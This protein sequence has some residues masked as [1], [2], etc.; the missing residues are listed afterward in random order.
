MK[1]QAVTALVVFAKAPVEGLAKT[2]LIPALGPK[3]AAALADRLLKRAVG[4]AASSGFAYIEL[5]VTPSLEHPSFQQLAA[6][7]PL[8]ITLQGE[9]DLGQRMSRCMHRLLS[10]YERVLLM[11]TDAP[12]LDSA[13]LTQA[14]EALA[15]HDAVFVPA[16]DGGYVL[17][18]LSSPQPALFDGIPWGS[19][20]VMSLTR[21]R[22][23]QSGLRLVEL[24]PMSDID[25]AK[26]L[27][28]LPQGWLP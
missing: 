21:D 27:I 23:Q 19:D 14:S 12:G 2:R 5:C 25:E 20:Q 4:T 8:S 15:H 26:D 3:G 17:I 1:G 18:G 28:Y 6:A 11:G 24:A 13:R 9:G 7:H 16:F 22:A 10:Q